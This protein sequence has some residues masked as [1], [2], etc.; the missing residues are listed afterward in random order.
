V[1]ALSVL[2]NYSALLYWFLFHP[3][4]KRDVRRLMPTV[5]AIPSLIVG[6]VLTLALILRGNYDALFGTWMCLFGL[7][8]LSSRHVL[9]RALWPL[10]FFYIGCGTICLLLP[11][12][13]FTN[14]WPMG[15]IFGIGEWI[16][17]FIFHYNR[18]PD[19]PSF[20]SFFKGRDPRE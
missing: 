4:V 5:D 20:G 8:N 16:G 11:A 7:T 12:V 13:S 14:P 10:G 19:S 18:I 3:D 17:G 6:G 15:I 9:P 2:A 1:F